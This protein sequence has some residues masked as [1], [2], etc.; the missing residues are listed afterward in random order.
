M[1]ELL[2]LLRRENTNFSIE[3]VDASKEAVKKAQVSGQLRPKMTHSRAS[4]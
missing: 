3:V 2:F 1:L 4:V